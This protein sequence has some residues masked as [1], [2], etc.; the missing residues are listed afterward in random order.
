MGYYYRALNRED[1]KN[2][3]DNKPLEVPASKKVV[4]IKECKK[5]ITS[6][7]YAGSANEKNYCWI[8]ACKDFEVCA[9]E[10]AIPQNGSYNTAK[11]RKRIAVI[12]S[13]SNNENYTFISGEDKSKRIIQTDVEN[14]T[15]DVFKTITSTIEQ[16]NTFVFDLSYPSEQNRKHLKRKVKI[17][18]NEYSYADWAKSGFV[19]NK[20]GS[21]PEGVPP[22]PSGN[23]Q[24]AKEILVLNEIPL[25]DIVKVLSLIEIDIL[26]AI[27]KIDEQN[28]QNEQY[29][30]KFDIL[31]EQMITGKISIVAN[32]YGMN[33]W[34][35]KKLYENNQN[36]FEL[37]YDILNM[38]ELAYEILNME[39]FKSLSAFYIL[40]IYSRL[41][42]E[43]RK[44][45][46][47]I[48]KTLDSSV[49]EKDVAI[50][51]DEIF[52]AV[53]V[54]EDHSAPIKEPEINLGGQDVV[55]KPLDYGYNVCNFY[56]LMLVIDYK[57]KKDILPTQGKTFKSDPTGLFIITR[58]KEI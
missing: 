10:F 1:I 7:V 20:D 8:S 12:E 50:L 28:K 43:K 22:I 25:D 34:L 38:F 41:K 57:S 31:L 21:K 52:I 23:V 39:E 49:E 58:G 26:Y 19:L 29:K 4:D 5:Q 2:W 37:A 6:H 9:S 36:M 13:R 56:D 16:I 3:E 35:F 40:S 51:E 48:I 24:K 53:Y 47:S 55:I 44:M 14:K 18:L 32:P 54:P 46:Y 11:K 42:D 30:K 27:Y 45:I 17:P 15:Y 33:Q